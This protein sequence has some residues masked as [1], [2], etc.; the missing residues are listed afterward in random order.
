MDVKGIVMK[1][2]KWDIES[3][4]SVGENIVF[5]CKLEDEEDDSIIEVYLTNYRIIW[6]NSEFVDCRLLKFISKYGVFVG[7]EDYNERNDIGT[8]EY[9]VYFGDTNFY[10]TFW[11]YSAE[12]WKEFYDEL[13][14]CVLEETYN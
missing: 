1:N 9:G 6:I 2:L 10:E 5:K 7:Y 12:V 11:F 13:S 14:R 3:L 8:G 4:L